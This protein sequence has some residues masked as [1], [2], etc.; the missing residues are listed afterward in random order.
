MRNIKL[1]V[2]SFIWGK[3]NKA[4][5]MRNIYLKCK[6]KNFQI[7]PKIYGYFLTLEQ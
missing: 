6:F 4:L 1:K 7:R 5:Y 2:I 3:F